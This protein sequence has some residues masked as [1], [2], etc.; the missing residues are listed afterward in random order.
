MEQKHVFTFYAIPRHRQDA[1]ILNLSPSTT[2]T[3]LFYIVSIMDAD[4]LATQGA[5][6]SAPMIFTMLNRI[7]LV[8]AR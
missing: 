2:R 1:G 3:D 6:A 7:N 5:R 4:V 8:P